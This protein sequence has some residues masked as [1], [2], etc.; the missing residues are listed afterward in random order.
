MR[1]LSTLIAVATIFAAT[2]ILQ[3]GEL[4]GIAHVVD[5]DTIGI[6]SIKIRL[7][8][9]DAPETDQ[10][11]LGEN[12]ER[13]T[14]GIEARNQLA[15]RIEGK[16]ILC[17]LTGTDR[18]GRS[19]GVCRLSN[20]DIN[21]WMVRSGWALAFT[22]YSTIYSTVEQEARAGKRGL[23]KGAFIAPW[24]WR[25]RDRKT[26][27]LGA[28][29][30]PINSQALLLAPASADAAPSPACIIKGNVNRKGERIYHLPGQTAYGHITMNLEKGKRWFCSV[31]EAQT[32]GW[33]PSRR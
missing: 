3:A 18:Y 6:G 23:W 2:N 30:V 11:C 14:C 19:L 24:N 17:T 4:N 21:R 5:G 7:E 8:G 20:E 12:A 25:H 13:T 9:I 26:E 33:R 10:L 31:E 1:I 27:I 15:A 22:R 28:L 32:A 16:E 29:S